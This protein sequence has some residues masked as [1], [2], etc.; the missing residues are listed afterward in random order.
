MNRNQA[1]WVD[2]Q[3]LNTSRLG[4]AILLFTDRNRQV[5]I[6]QETSH[7]RISSSWRLNVKVA[8]AVLDNMV[9]EIA[10]EFVDER[11]VR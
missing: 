6:S 2:S 8:F 10:I 9:G 1:K 7:G 11:V 3:K 4:H 5:R